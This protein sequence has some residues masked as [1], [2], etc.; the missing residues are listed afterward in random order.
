MKAGDFKRRLATA[1]LLTSLFMVVEVAGG[2]I[3]GSLSLLGDAGHMSRDVLALV[4][5]FSA[6]NIAE[7][8]PTKSKTFGFHRVEILASF[9]N[10]IVLLVVGL[11]ILWESYHR[12]RDPQP[13]HS[14][15]MLWVA[16]IGLGVNAF[17]A[18]RLHGS[19]D[20]NIKSAFLHVVTDAVVSVG[21]IFA[22]LLIAWTGNPV[23]DPGLSAV[24]SLVVIASAAYLIRDSVR[25]LLEFAPDDVDFDR[26]IQ[27]MQQVEGV[28]GIHNVHLWS[29]CSNINV[30]DAHVVTPVTD[31]MEVENIKSALKQRLERYGVRHATLEF[32]CEQ[33]ALDGAVEKIG[34]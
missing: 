33:C 31:L 18:L 19:Q 15:T 29:L 14:I 34:H 4:I 2:L 17:I 23:F 20:L 22:A 5:S 28:A 30:I 32:E 11:W 26:L 13:V 10:G 12:F 16:V 21:V 6:R 27:E 1:I 7:R 3:S 8:L 25:I 9:L 24:I